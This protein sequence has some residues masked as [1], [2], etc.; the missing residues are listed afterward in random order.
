MKEGKTDL[1]SLHKGGKTNKRQV[2]P[3]QQPDKSRENTQRQEVES[4]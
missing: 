3:I 2:K 4:K 1:N